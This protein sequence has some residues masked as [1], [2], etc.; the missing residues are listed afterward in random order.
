MNQY[1]KVAFYTLGCKLNFSETSTIARQLQEAGFA[2][3]EFQ[4]SADIYV[5]NTCSVTENADKKCKQLVKK[6]LNFNPNAF[7]V[8]LGCYAQLKPEEIAQIH[9]VDL[10]LGAQ[11]KFNLTDYL[12]NI[13]KNTA[14]IIQNS[15]IKETKEFVPGY[16]IDDR[17]RTF[18]K[19]QDGCDYFCSFCTIP[20]ARGKSRNASIDKTLV[21]AKKIAQTKVKEV[22]LTGVNIGDFGQGG[23]E[24]FYQLIQKLDK[25]DGIDRFRISSIEPNLLSTDIIEFVAK[26]DKFVPHFHIPMQSG[27]DVLLTAMRRKYDKALYQSRIEKIKELMPECCIG[28]DVIVGFPGETDEIFEE[29]YQFLVDLDVSYLHVFTYSERANTGALKIKEVVP[30]NIRKERSKRLRILSEKKKRAFYKFNEN[31]T[32]EVLFEA[33]Q[34]HGIMNGFTSN[35]VKVKTAYNPLIVNHVAPVKMTEVDRDG[36]MKIEFIEKRQL[37]ELKHLTN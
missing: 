22:V 13:E 27:S 6:A 28:V 10:V 33:D 36:L 18:M 7:V 19:I 30:M 31:K 29:T 32:E 5:I 14:A 35:Y 21:E 8:I 34:E 2:K 12:D 25:I 11:E 26:S 16:S 15:S 1:Q 3:V 9:G 23:E 20:L 4:E 24:N 17:T 37:T